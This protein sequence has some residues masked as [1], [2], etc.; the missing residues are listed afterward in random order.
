MRKLRTA[1]LDDPPIHEHVHVVGL[2]VVEDAL[3]V[4]DHERA[5]LRADE[6]L[7]AARDHLQRVD[8]EARVGLVE[9]RDPRLQHRHL[10]DLDPLLLAAREAVVQVARRELARDLEAVHLGEERRPELLDGDRVV[11][12]ARARL[13]DGVDGRAQEVGHGHAGDRVR[14]LEGEEE[15]AL[16]A[17]VGGRLGDVLAVEADPAAGDPVGRVA[18]D[19]VGERR[20]ARAVRAHDRVHLVRVDREVDAADDLCAVL[21]R[22]AQIGEL[23]QGHA[24]MVA[25]ACPRPD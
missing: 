10:Q 18:G 3:V 5:H 14:V 4:R 23:Q 19:R 15:P 2:N 6:L 9:H 22:D 25:H 8:V 16:R 24:H 20:L 7:D 1:F 12:A 11:D 21:E 13:A 17:L